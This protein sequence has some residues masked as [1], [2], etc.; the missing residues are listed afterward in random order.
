MNPEWIAILFKPIMKASLSFTGKFWWAVVRSWI[1]PTLVDNTLTPNHDVLVASILVGYNIDWANLIVEQILEM[2][3]KR[4]TCIPFPCLIYRLCIESGV[5][6]L[7][8]LVS[9]IE[10][11]ETLDAS[12]IK[13]DDN[14][15]VFQ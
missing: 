8:H 14:S 15:V 12:Q 11:Q 1:W 4:S 6:I 9:L 2:A 10:V 13:A 5:E 3:M 7:H